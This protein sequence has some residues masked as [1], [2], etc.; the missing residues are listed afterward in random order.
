MSYDD[1][2]PKIPAAAVSPEDAMMMARL[3]AD[4]VPVYGGTSRWRAH[5]AGCR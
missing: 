3:Y 1:N 4:G 5:G 2:Q